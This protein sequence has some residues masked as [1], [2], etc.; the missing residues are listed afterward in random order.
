MGHIQ[1][2]LENGVFDLNR[3]VNDR[4]EMKEEEIIFAEDKEPSKE[5]GKED[6]KVEE[7]NPN[8]TAEYRE[9]MKDLVEE[10]LAHEEIPSDISIKQSSKWEYTEED[11]ILQT[12]LHLP[13][14]KIICI[15]E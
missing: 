13:L 15:L 3:A 5:E 14:E 9:S 12:I 10:P 1:S 6:I 11:L 8:S 4:V 7:N 2:H